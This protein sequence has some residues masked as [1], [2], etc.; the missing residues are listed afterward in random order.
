[1]LD[2]NSQRFSIDIDYH[3]DENLR[4]KQKQVEDNCNRVVL[5]EQKRQFKYEGSASRRTGP[6]ADSENAAFVDLRVWK[7]GLGFEISIGLTKIIRFDPAAIRTVN[8]TVYATPSDADMI[9]AKILAVLNRV[10]LQHRDFVDIFLYGNTLR[11][12][13]PER[14]KKKIQAL[15]ISADSI[16]KRI[17]DLNK[18]AG[19]SRDARRVSMG[20]HKASRS[21]K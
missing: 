18:N 7:E 9:E 4:E 13:S 12:D 11:P 14:V 8:G 3:W 15:A 16:Q 10:Y 20:R 17:Q 5:R 1:L 6:G 21:S 19:S 2:N